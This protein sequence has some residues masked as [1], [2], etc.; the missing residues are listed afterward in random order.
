MTSLLR[1]ADTDNVCRLDITAENA[2]WEYVGF[3]LVKLSEGETY[4]GNSEDKEVCLVLVGG[5][6][7]IDAGDQQFDNIGERMSP[8]DGIPPYSVYL[9]PQ[10]DY[11]I[12][13]TTDLE[14]GVCSSEQATGELPIRLITPEDVVV[15]DRGEGSNLRK[16]HNIM[17]GETVAERLLITE[18]FTP[19]G[20]WS[21]YPPHKHDSDR[22]PEESYLEETYYHRIN[23]QQGFVFQR[24]YTDDRSID[25]SMAVE[26]GDC[27]LVPGGYHPVGVP[28]GYESYYLN[29]MAGPAREWKFYNDPDHEWIIE[30]QNK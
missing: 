13:A 14:V 10:T 6:A 29:T 3:Q 22:L 2:G 25:E 4:T 18:V 16:I 12:T 5:K 7:N 8:F 23:P 26:D 9:P 21:S 27:V 20:N 30:A 19:S 24:V 17:M 1:K 11:S 15:M 28:H